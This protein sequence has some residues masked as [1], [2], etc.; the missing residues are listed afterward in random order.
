MKQMKLPGSR[1]EVD[2]LERFTE[3]AGLT[4]RYS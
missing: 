2:A 3:T 1:S 4:R